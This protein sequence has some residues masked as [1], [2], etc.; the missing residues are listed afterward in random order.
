MTFYVVYRVLTCILWEW[1]D[2]FMCVCLPCRDTAGQE[3]YQ[4]ITKQ[5]YRRAQV[6]LH[7][8]NHRS[9]AAFMGHCNSS[10]FNPFLWILVQGIIF[11][12]DITNELSYQHIAKWAS[13]VDEVRQYVFLSHSLALVAL[14]NDR[15]FVVLLT[16]VSASC[17]PHGS[18]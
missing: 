9:Q 2:L 3:R 5:Y 4:T 17:T 12:Y 10:L 18:V 13:D 15:V 7:T 1:R 16:E 8:D 11:V 14:Y 6:S